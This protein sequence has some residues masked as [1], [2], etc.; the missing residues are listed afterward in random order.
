MVAAPVRELFEP[1]SRTRQPE[2]WVRPELIGESLVS[3]WDRV[4]ADTLQDGDADPLHATR[5]DDRSG[6]LAALQLLDGYLTLSARSGDPADRLRASRDTLQKHSDSL[7]PRWQTLDDL[8]GILLERITPSREERLELVKRF[9]PPQAW[10][11]ETENPFEPVG[12]TA[13]CCR[14]L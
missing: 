10:Y 14:P 4:S 2:P 11:D 9:P 5:D 6:L 7:F 3:A 13:N 1:F 8:E 12:E